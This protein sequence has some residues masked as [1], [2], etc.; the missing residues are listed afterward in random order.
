MFWNKF[1]WY[2]LLNWNNK[3]ISNPFNHVLTALS[4]IKG[5]LVEDWVDS[6]DWQLKQCLDHDCDGYIAD[7]NEILW[8]E[9]EAAFKLAWK[10]GEKAQRA[11]EQLMRLTMKDLNID[12][13]MATFERLSL[14]VG[15][16]LDAQGTIERYQCGLRNN[17]H[18][19]I[20]NWDCELV[21]MDK[22]KTAA[23][24]EVHKVW[25]TIAAGLDFCN[26]QKP[27]HNPSVTDAV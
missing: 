26:K 18:W 7:S 10:D 4:Y 11:Y 27:S 6:Q 14:A 1:C 24:V 17:V 19:Q 8:D 13:Y 23:Q 3:A 12:S 9:F 15:L 5:L 16:E 22:W 2:H 21:M 20:L 25:K